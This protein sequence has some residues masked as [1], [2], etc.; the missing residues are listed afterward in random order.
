MKPILLWDVMSTLVHDPFFEEM[1]EFFDVPFE[2]LVPQLQPGAWVEFELGKR[3]ERE[4]LRDFFADRRD[5][6]HRGFVETVRRSYRWL[7]GMEALLEELH[8]SGCAMHTFSN[9]PVWYQM[10]EEKLD[11]SRFARWS[12]VSCLI[13][14]RKPDPAAY[15]HVLQELGVAASQC[16]FVDDRRSNCGAAKAA[17]IEAICFDGADSL[18]E[19]LR[20]A[21]VL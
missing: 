15:A 17:G 8:G 21:G 4:F 6:D 7:P 9:Y 14:L 1:P 11:V 12:F 16:I 3:T 10:I 5:F 18:R 13:G 19:S 20:E 2:E